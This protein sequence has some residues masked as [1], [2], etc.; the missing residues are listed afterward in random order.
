MEVDLD[1]DFKHYL[2]LWYEEWD[3]R[4]DSGT[5]MKAQT[6]QDEGLD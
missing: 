2:C 6:G 4:D 3:H 1:L 5:V